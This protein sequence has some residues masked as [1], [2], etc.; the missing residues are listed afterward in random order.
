MARK[1]V[2]IENRDALGMTMLNCAWQVTIF[3]FFYVFALSAQWWRWRLHSPTAEPRHE[4][5]RVFR[6]VSGGRVP[7]TYWFLF[8]LRKYDKIV[9]ALYVHAMYTMRNTYAHTHSRIEL[10]PSIDRLVLDVPVSDA[11]R[12]YVRSLVQGFPLMCYNGPD[13]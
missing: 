12:A 4:S 9:M 2:L 5:V 6:L 11:L 3:P 1:Q 13:L 7:V 8:K 10:K